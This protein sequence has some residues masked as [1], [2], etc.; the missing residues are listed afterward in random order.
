VAGGAISARPDQLPIGRIAR[1][2]APA[3]DRPVF[4]LGRL[5][6]QFIV[7]IVT[8]VIHLRIQWVIGDDVSVGYRHAI[9]TRGHLIVT[10]VT[11]SAVD[12]IGFSL[13]W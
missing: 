4:G 6:T 11:P 2:A 8:I 9:V 7:T 10:T 13:A 1:D 5:G 12:F 3:A